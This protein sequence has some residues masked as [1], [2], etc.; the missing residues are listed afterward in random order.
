[1]VKVPE[2]R[3]IDCWPGMAGY[4]IGGDLSSGPKI[5]RN[6]LVKKS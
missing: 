2:V 3:D 4:L 5:L 1:M 6:R